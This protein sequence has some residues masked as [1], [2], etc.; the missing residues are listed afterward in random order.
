MTDR[1]NDDP[2]RP[3]IAFITEQHVGLRT[4]SEN[5]Q[6]FAD[7]DDRIVAR[8]APVTYVG[9]PRWW[10][11]AKIVPSAVRSALRGRDQ[12]RAA[13]TTLRP[14]AA[15]FMT[16][17]PAALG[18]SFTRR[19]P[20]V[21][22]VDDT[23]ILYDRMSVHYDQG[24]D[25][26]GPLK[27]WKHRTNVTA[28]RGAHA[29]LPMSQW[30]RRSLVDDYG[31]APERAIV[32]PTGLDLG[33]WSPGDPPDGGPM[34]ILFVGGHFDRKGGHSLLD[35]LST[36]EPGTTE[37]HLVTRDAVAERPGVHV[38]NGMQPNSPE[39]IEL[40][41]TCEVFVLP[42]RAEAFPNALVEAC[43]SGLACVVSRVGAMDEM[44]VEGESGFVIEAGDVEALSN[45]LGRLVADVELRRRM[46]HAARLHAERHY[47]GRT[48]AGL[49]VDQL[50]DAIDA[51]R[52][53]SGDR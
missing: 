43:A 7:S 37:T 26:F 30:A 18:G 27:T 3:T 51:A 20:Y 24:A 10:D 35:A 5:L 11:R 39:L 8:W 52:T 32:V 53:G 40:Y 49:V 19:K 23:P 17:T 29:V 38:H 9:E 6:R 1:P 16:Q 28:L 41:R 45:R 50:L 46:G 36:L 48:N 14:D 2:A 25:R 4:Y 21:I 31:V 33:T 44:I 13:V 34:R 12:A 22:M 15:L 42:S 47:D